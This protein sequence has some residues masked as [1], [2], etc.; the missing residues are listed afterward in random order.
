MWVDYVARQAV[1][2]IGATLRLPSL[3]LAVRSG[4]L[5]FPSDGPT[6]IS[7][8]SHGARLRT[9]HHTLASLLVG[10][11]RVP[12]ILWL[13]TADYHAP[14]PEPLQE[15]VQCGLQV[16]CSDGQYGPHTKYF[17]A[18]RQYAGAGVSVITVDDDVLYPWWFVEKLV[19]DPRAVTAYRA[20]EIALRGGEFAPY[21]QWGRVRTTTPSPRHFATG[22]SGVAYPPAMVDFVAAQ[23]DAFLRAAPSADDVWLNMCAVRSGH[24]VRQ[25]FDKPKEFPLVPGS[26][27]VALVRKNLRG[28]ND[29]QLAASYSAEDIRAVVGAS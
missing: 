23:G 1:A 16:R 5:E 24:Y 21:R 26:Q 29:V 25:V 18:F 11:R 19:V 12:T 10:T 20:H 2:Q 15:L 4:R 14:W 27:S 8:T 7:L 17:G 28:G 3:R 9:V 22:V 13:D 6:V